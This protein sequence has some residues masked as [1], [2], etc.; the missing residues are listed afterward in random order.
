MNKEVISEKQ[1]IY[2][3][4][5]FIVAET[6]ILTRGME[7]KKDFWIAIILGII[8]SIPFMLMFSRLH[9][10]YPN[11]DLF[12]INEDVFGKILGKIISFLMFYY[13]ATNMMSV[14]YVF[15]DFI[16]SVSLLKTPKGVTYMSL[17]LLCI[18]V[19]KEGIE[20]MAKWTEIILPIILITLFVGVV[21]LIPQMR[22]VN[23]QPFFT[24]KIGAIMEGSIFTFLFPLSE[25]IAFTMI[26]TGLKKQGS[27]NRLYLIGLIFGGGLILILVLTE[28]LVLGVNDTLSFYFP[29]YNTFTRVNIGVLLQRLE[30]ISGATFLL[31]GFIK[32]SVLLMAVSRGVAKVFNFNDYRF[33]VTPTALIISNVSYFFYESTMFMFEW[34]SD[35]WGYFAFPFE[36][37]MPIVIW[38]GAE[39]RKK[40]KA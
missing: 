35:F 29:G 18:W 17:T 15:N 8:I 26:F 36:F 6:F 5:L 12:D 28:V 24:E 30:I 32:I 27:F 1:G 25:T 21:L 23:M 14:M 39:V 34:I 16:V 37:V 31:G 7:A 19:V 38:I 10:L 20:V 13:V 2:L 9:R 3:I 22:L 4:T 40:I 33:I 11:K